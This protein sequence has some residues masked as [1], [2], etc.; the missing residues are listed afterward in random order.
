M[1]KIMMEIVFSA[2][3]INGGFEFGRI[4]ILCGYFAFFAG[5][6]ML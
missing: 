5:R 4:I 3:H 6:F 2:Q 1:E